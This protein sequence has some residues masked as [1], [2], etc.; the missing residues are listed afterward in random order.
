MGRLCWLQA[1]SFLK[2]H[3]QTEEDKSS[4]SQSTVL[5]FSTT[6]NVPFTL[7]SHLPAMGGDLNQYGG[8]A[9]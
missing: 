8:V 6:L 5:G 3:K 7:S 2:G 1:E 4:S 9:L